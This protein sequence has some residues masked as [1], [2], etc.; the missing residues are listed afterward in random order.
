MPFKRS[1]GNFLDCI[2]EGYCGGSRSELSDFH[3][4]LDSVQHFGHV[5]QAQAADFFLDTLPTLGGVSLNEIP[6]KLPNAVDYTFQLAHSASINVSRFWHG[7]LHLVLDS[8]K[9]LDSRLNLL[10]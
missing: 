3:F 1:V 4:L 7:C 8:A 9:L 10:R 6:E 5:L 2:Q